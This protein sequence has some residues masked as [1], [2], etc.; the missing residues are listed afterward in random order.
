MFIGAIGVLNRQDMDS[1]AGIFITYQNLGKCDD[2]QGVFVY[3][4]VFFSW[5]TRKQKN[6]NSTLSWLHGIIPIVPESVE[7]MQMIEVSPSSELFVPSCY[8]I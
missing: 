2:E 4:S 7:P 6:R 5:L 3:K 8:S 1:F